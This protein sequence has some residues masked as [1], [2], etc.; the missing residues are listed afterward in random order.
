ME[1]SADINYHHLKCNPVPQ[2]VEFLR[3]SFQRFEYKRRKKIA[4]M[5]I[6][7]SFSSQSLK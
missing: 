5:K 6:H 1:V 4:S 2:I 3:I 7:T